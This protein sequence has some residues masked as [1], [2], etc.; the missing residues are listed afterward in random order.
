MEK[1]YF[2]DT[3]LSTS[4]FRTGAS[5]IMEVMTLTRTTW[6]S[7]G[8]SVCE[9]PPLNHIPRFTRDMMVQLDLPR[10]RS[11]PIFATTLS[12]IGYLAGDYT[13]R[14]AIDLQTLEWQDLGPVDSQRSLAL[15]FDFPNCPRHGGSLGERIG[16]PLPGIS[17]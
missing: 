10:P 9:L 17:T 12:P 15:V 5:I 11:H 16:L 4:F 6:L 14:A 7:P 3:R 1:N 13:I 8:P 2:A